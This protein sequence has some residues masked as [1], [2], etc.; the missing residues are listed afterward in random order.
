MHNRTKLSKRKSTMQD[1]RRQHNRITVNFPIDLKIDSQITIEGKVKDI[2][3]K[4]AFIEIKNSVAMQV[5]DEF[6]FHAK[7]TQ[8]MN[9]KNLQGTMCI[10]RIAPG[11]GIAVYFT[12]MDEQSSSRLNELFI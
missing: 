11:Q 3:P 8:D 10:S 6:D 1:N 7:Y 5:N 2:S 12:E 9:E 4:S